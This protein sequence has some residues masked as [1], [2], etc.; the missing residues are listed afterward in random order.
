MKEI[1]T[2]ELQ[3]KLKEGQSL[4]LIDVREAEEVAAGMI[5]GTV[6]IPMGEVVERLSEFNKNEPYI[7]ICR[8]G[9]RSG[10]VTAY[11]EQEGYDVTNMVGGMLEWEGEVK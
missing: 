5:P 8:S 1:T 4:H 2:T 6:H 11:L 10:Q 7:F 9:N 3:N